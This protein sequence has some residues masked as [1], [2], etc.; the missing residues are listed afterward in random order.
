VQR[1]ASL[2]L[3]S[4]A[5][6]PEEPHRPTRASDEEMRGAE[7]ANRSNLRASDNASE[8]TGEQ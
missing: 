7:R 4:L 8:Q 6:A 1:W 2:F 5:S 3:E